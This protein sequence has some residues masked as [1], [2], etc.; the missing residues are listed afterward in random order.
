VW[1]D[2][3]FSDI[4]LTGYTWANLDETRTLFYELGALPAG[5]LDD[6]T[7]TFA[8]ISAYAEEAFSKFDT[9]DA[10]GWISYMIGFTRTVSYS[11]QAGF[12]AVT[13]WIDG[14]NPYYEYSPQFQAAIPEH[15]KFE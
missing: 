4:D 14:P 1:G 6:Y 11:S 15:F 2:N 10:S 12:Q 13:G 5:S 8:G 3:D 7:A 9:T